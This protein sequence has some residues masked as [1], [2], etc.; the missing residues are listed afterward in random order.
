MVPA[1]GIEPVASSVTD[2]RSTLLNYGVRMCCDRCK[3]G[4][5]LFGMDTVPPKNLVYWYLKL[6]SNQQPS[7][8]EGAAL[9]LSY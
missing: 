3:N 2:W 6:D 1:A 7:P 9:P 4:G 8:Y 5:G